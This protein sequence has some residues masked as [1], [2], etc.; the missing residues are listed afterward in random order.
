MM[1]M[2]LLHPLLNPDDDDDGDD[3]VNLK[4]R[5]RNADRIA[6]GNARAKHMCC[7]SDVC[8]EFGVFDGCTI[9]VCVCAREKRAEIAMNQ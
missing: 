5:G 2:P 7:G 8:A 9:Y 1:I 4:P 3:A 6:I